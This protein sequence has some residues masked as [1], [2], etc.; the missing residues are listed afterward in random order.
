LASRI[1]DAPLLAGNTLLRVALHVLEVLL[2]LADVLD[3]SILRHANIALGAFHALRAAQQ[4]NA[5]HD[6]DPTH[7]LSHSFN[8]VSVS[9][10]KQ[11]S[12][13]AEPTQRPRFD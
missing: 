3:C 11:R 6:D 10:L 1:F 7:E 2:F 5:G 13:C 8:L 4:R 12:R 9:G